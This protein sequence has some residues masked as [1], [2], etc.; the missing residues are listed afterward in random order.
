MESLRQPSTGLWRR[1]R[2]K[3]LRRELGFIVLPAAHRARINRLAHLH[4]AGGR[5]G[6]VACCDGRLQARMLPFQAAKLRLSRSARRSR[7]RSR[8]F[9]IERLRRHWQ[10]TARVFHQPAI[11]LNR[12]AMSS[13]PERPRHAAEVGHPARQ[14]DIPKIPPAVNENR[15]RKESGQ[16]SDVHV[17]IGH[18][19]ITRTARAGASALSRSRCS[20]AS[21]RME[22]ASSWAMHS[23]G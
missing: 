6:P 12:A 18:L 1:Y 9:R 11:L 7:D 13:V 2:R 16:Q 14:G 4:E 23:Q 22:G 21:R 20:S 5:F 15:P 17:I 8:S 3:Q 19:S 10:C